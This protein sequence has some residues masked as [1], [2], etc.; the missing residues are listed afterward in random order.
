MKS[1][2]NGYIGIEF[3]PVVLPIGIDKAQSERRHGPVFAVRFF[4]VVY[5]YIDFPARIQGIR[6]PAAIPFQMREIAALLL[7]ELQF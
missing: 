4:D 1:E 2:S 6:N 3:L 7:P 5:G